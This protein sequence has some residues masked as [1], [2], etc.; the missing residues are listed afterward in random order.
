MEPLPILGSGFF[1]LGQKPIEAMTRGFITLQQAAGLFLL[2][3][4]AQRLSPQTLIFYRTRLERFIKWC[5]GEELD[6]LQELETTHIRKFLIT[7]QSKSAHYQHGVARAIRAWLNFCKAD[8]LISESPFDRVKMPKLDK[9]IPPS[10]SA[11]EVRKIVLACRTE[12]DQA[13]VLM[14]LDTGLRASELVV[15][16]MG[17]MEMQDGVIHVRAGKGKKGRVV[18]IGAKA[19]KQLQRYFI[20]ERGDVQP[21]EPLF[22]SQRGGERLTYDGVSSLFKR[23][24]KKVGIRHLSA[25]TFRRTFAIE[26][27][28]N[29]MNIYILQRIMGHA[30][31]QVLRTYLALV[32]DDLRQAHKQSSPVDNIL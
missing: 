8:G 10:F 19:R 27:L 21:D 30:D 13:I 11:D 31:L 20:L 15:L 14:L 23:L 17:D 25:H 18:P 22:T 5:D 29:G 28:R 3:R 32:E 6:A 7:L 9:K 26:C 12:R 24:K 4:E 2:D 1:Y 16:N